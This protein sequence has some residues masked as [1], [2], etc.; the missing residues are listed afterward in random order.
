[1]YKFFNHFPMNIT[2]G[3]GDVIRKHEQRKK[4]HCTTV[5]E[6]WHNAKIDEVMRELSSWFVFFNY[7]SP[8]IHNDIVFFCDIKIQIDI[9]Y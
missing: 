6:H 1:M 4:I 3:S 2:V 5:S 8:K 7:H 9:S